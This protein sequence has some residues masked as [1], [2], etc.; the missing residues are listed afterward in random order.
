[1]T[2]ADLTDTGAADGDEAARRVV[3]SV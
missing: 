2:D 1:M 3:D